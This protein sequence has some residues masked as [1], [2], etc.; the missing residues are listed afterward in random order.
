MQNVNTLG[1]FILFWTFS[2]ALIWKN[3]KTVLIFTIYIHKSQII[4]QTWLNSKCVYQWQQF[5]YTSNRCVMIVTINYIKMLQ[6]TSL[7]SCSV[8]PVADNFVYFIRLHNSLDRHV[9]TANQFKVHVVV[10]VLIFRCFCSNSPI[11]IS[12]ILW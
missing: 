4:T 8:L 2:D 12:L 5:E 3:D 11:T 7:T 6:L 10:N 1:D 9:L